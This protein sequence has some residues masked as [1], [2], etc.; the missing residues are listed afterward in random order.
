MEVHYNYAN[1]Y[2]TTFEYTKEFFNKSNQLTHSHIIAF[3]NV[4]RFIYISCTLIFKGNLYTLT[5]KRNSYVHI[6]YTHI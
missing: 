3:I 1:Y 5:H 4:S 6:N 2:H